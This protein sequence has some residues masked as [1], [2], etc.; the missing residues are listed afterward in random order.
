MTRTFARS[1]TRIL[2]LLLL[3]C[4][5]EREQ[6]SFRE[7]PPGATAFPAVQT[8]ELQAGPRTTDP[9]AGAYQENRWAV[10]QGYTFYV[11]YNCAGCH[12]PG[13]GGGM[14]PPLN[15]DEW[16]YG[17]DPENIFATI[18]EGRPNGMPSFRGRIDNA[19]LW[20]LV[21]YVRTMSG[22]TPKD[23]HPGRTD[24]MQESRPAMDALPKRQLP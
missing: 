15:D 11:Q 16:I 8:S 24:H 22:L 19:Q 20:Q 6:R 14:G 23:L 5:C 2:A 18:V 12:A 21:A 1:P 17:S 4:A 10:G 3:L 9:S 13:G 7:T